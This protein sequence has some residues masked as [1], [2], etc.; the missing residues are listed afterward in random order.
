M[1]VVVVYVRCFFPSFFLFI[2]IQIGRST[3]TIS[4]CVRFCEFEC[5]FGCVPVCVCETKRRKYLGKER[6]L[7]TSTS[8]PRLLFSYVV[9]CEV[10]FFGY[11]FMLKALAAF[12]V[13]VVVVCCPAPA[14]FRIAP[15]AFVREC[16][17][18]PAVWL[19]H[20]IFRHLSF[21][22]IALVFPLFALGYLSHFNHLP[23]CSHTH[24]LSISLARSLSFLFGH[25]LF[26]EN[27]FQL[28]CVCAPASSATTRSKIF[29]YIP[30]KTHTHTRTLCR[31]FATRGGERHT[32]CVN[33]QHIK[34]WN[35]N[36]WRF[37]YEF[38]FHLAQ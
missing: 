37:C 12:V 9:V 4:L 22:S 20:F 6:K 5:V 19:L 38:Y 16:V 27:V 7:K 32:K 10:I 1:C 17:Y 21:I 28:R 13:V 2:V 23:S 14:S 29:V 18:E 33:V 30:N 25:P 24:T 35:T 26:R 36:E 11:L 31:A 34:F 3:E 8:R 15:W